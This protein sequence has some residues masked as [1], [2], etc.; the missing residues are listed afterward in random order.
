MKKLT[1]L[2]A[3]VALSAS[4]FSAAPVMAEGS[5]SANFG[6]ASEYIFRG[7]LQNDSS[8]SAGIDYE[9]GGFYIGTWAADVD[10]GLEV[11]GY[12][13][14][15]FETESGFSASLGYTTY[16]YTGDFDTEYNEVNVNV[17]FGFASLE[18][19]FGEHEVDGGDDEDYTFI[20]LTLE[21]NGFYGTYGTFSDDWEGEYLELGYGTEIGGFDA[22]VS[23]VFSEKGLGPE[24]QYWV[25]D[26]DEAV[27]FSIGK[28]F[29]L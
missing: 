29:D 19:S 1:K 20:A 4:A 16:Q 10:D 24:D 26:D 28:S 3:A 25:G 18:Y 21:H 5:L 11:D 9:N 14:W 12:L 6:F 13:G 2:A 7:I 15:G 17:G 23:L 8:G 27:V 22:G